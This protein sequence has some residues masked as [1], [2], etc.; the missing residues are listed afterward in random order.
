MNLAEPTVLRVGVTPS[1]TRAI[2]RLGANDK[3]VV[4]GAIRHIAANP[5]AG[6]ERKGDL[7]DITLYKFK[8]N[9][10]DIL[11]TYQLLPDR[12]TST[13]LIL[14]AIGSNQNFDA[15]VNR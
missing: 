4:D 14:L 13:D 11:L 7:A 9:E 6:Q 1:F 10:Q 15:S 3:R 5:L 12:W 2:K 8:L